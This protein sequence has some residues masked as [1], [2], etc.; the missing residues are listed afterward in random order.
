MRHLLRDS[1][2]T[3]V[4]L[5]MRL[6]AGTLIWIAL[7]V[8]LAGWALSKL[9]RENIT[10]QFQAELTIHINQLISLLTVDSDGKLLMPVAL[11]DPRL[12]QPFS[13]L[14]WQVDQ[15]AGDTLDKV[16][17]VLRSRSLWDQTLRTNADKRNGFYTLS[18]PDSATITA[19]VRTIFPAETPNRPLRVIVAADQNTLAEPVGRF[20]RMLVLSLGALVVGLSLAAVF[21]V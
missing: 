8:A 19:L 4:S 18:G 1:R 20:T 16:Q 5:R 7:S 17:G 14:Y 15:L 13:G 21:Q 11:S 10:Q 3:F 12:D 6:L 9:F 2:Y